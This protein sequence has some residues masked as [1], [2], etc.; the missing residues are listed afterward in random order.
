MSAVAATT[1]GTDESNPCGSSTH[2]Y[3]SPS[4]SRSPRVR[5]RSSSVI[6]EPWRNSTARS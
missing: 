3:D 2:T 5:P 1:G 4:F 6:H